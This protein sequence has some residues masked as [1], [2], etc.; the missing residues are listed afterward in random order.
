MYD[1][2]FLSKKNI[3]NLNEHILTDILKLDNISY[4]QKKYYV[5][6]LINNMKK[7]FSKLKKQKL[8]K[9]DQNGLQKVL[10]KFND[11]SIKFTVNEIY[12]SRNSN[13][14]YQQNNTYQ[15]N[16]NYQQ[17]KFNPNFNPNNFNERPSFDMSNRNTNINQMNINRGQELNNDNNIRFMDRP[18]FTDNARNN[19]QENFRNNFSNNDI[20][21]GNLNQKNDHES[22]DSKL[23]SLRTIFLPITLNFISGS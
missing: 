11:M 12:K 20:R 10:K 16:T 1:K 9:M 15:Q 4:D 14:N 23:A 22:I 18:N 13:T 6:I 3:S 2:I 19:V 7:V 21:M 8:E 17:N 5:K